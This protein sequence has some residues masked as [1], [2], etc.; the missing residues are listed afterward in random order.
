[1]DEP[2]D[3]ENKK[4]KRYY[5]S[6]YYGATL[7]SS[8]RSLKRNQNAVRFNSTAV[9]LGPVSNMLIVGML[10]CV[11]GLMYLTQVTKTTSYGYQASDL[12]TTREDLIKQNQVLEVEST[13]LQALERI[14]NSDVAKELTTPTDVQYVR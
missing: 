13:R 4:K 9:K 1:M 12:R 2:G 14:K 5:M 10:V 8:R 7:R 11:L 3:H 6:N